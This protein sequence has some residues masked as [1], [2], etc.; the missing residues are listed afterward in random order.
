MPVMDA[1]AARPS[2]AVPIGRLKLGVMAATRAW[3]GQRPSAGVAGSWAQ[4]TRPV[5]GV[6]S[7]GVGVDHRHPADAADRAQPGEHRARDRGLRQR[8][9]RCR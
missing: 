3:A 8:Q 6:S 5:P 2:A 9:A 1:L 4:E 7:A